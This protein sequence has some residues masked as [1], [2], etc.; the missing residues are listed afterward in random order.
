MKKVE[1]SVLEGGNILPGNEGKKSGGEGG[2][3]LFVLL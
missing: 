1:N 2:L 3:L